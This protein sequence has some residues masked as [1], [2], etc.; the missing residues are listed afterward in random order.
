MIRISALVFSIVALGAMPAAAKPPELSGRI[1]APRP[2][3]CH[4]YDY[5][6]WDLYR[7]ELWTDAATLPGESFALSLTYETEFTRGKL[8]ETSIEEMVRLS[9]RSAETFAA[10]RR[11]L[12][13]AFRDV[14]P[15]DRITAWRAGSDRLRFFVNGEETGA[16]THHADLFLDIWLGED[17]RHAAGR[18][19]LLAGRCDG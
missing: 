10:A 8:V 11:E 16:L 2:A 12:E 13:G 7:A 18:R 3:A 1:E 4:D 14:R 19:N 17:A 15:G 6:V 5:L 9:G